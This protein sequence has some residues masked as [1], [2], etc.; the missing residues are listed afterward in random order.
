MI[1]SLVGLPGSGKSSVGAALARRL[2]VPFIDTD[3][4]AERRIGMSIREYFE[5]EGEGAFRELEQAVIEEV[6]SGDD[7]VI[8][9]GGGAVLR[10][11]NR[12]FLR[13]RGRV[14]YLHATPDEVFRRLR[15]DTRRPLLQ[16]DDVLGKLRDL[17]DQRNPIYR[18]VAHVEVATGRSTVSQV[19]ALV[20]ERLN[21]TPGPAGTPPP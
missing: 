18:S 15:R 7:G 9:T 21:A 2:D 19:A 1:L 3:K 14:V 5:S 13:S 16:V 12:T 11:V 8:A 10:E 17:Y 20:L 4:V 6:M